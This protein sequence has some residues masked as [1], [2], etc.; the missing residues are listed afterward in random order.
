MH[1]QK[2]QKPYTPS[3]KVSLSSE[4]VH[5]HC[6][7]C[8]RCS[9]T[10]H[11]PTH[12]PLF[13]TRLSTSSLFR[14][15]SSY[16]S[17]HRRRKGKKKKKEKRC[18]SGLRLASQASRSEPQLLLRASS[19]MK[20]YYAFFNVA[21][22]QLKIQMCASISINEENNTPVMLLSVVVIATCMRQ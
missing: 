4:L 17:C 20:S 19:G 15:L 10:P 9:L 21:M 22:T 13:P 16:Y 6:G 3:Q 12:P 8:L 2:K 1:A 18:I 14:S 11:A 5:C 7:C